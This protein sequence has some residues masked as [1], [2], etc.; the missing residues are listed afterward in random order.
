V[1]ADTIALLAQCER[2]RALYR[3]MLSVALEQTRAAQLTIARQ[4]EQLAE[5]RDERERLARSVFSE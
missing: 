2:E 4:R 5:Y 1:T 3:L